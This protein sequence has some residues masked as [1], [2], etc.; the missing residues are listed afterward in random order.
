MNSNEPP[1]KSQPQS[2]QHFRLSVRIFAGLVC[3]I[4]TV[5]CLEIGLRL[6][7]FA[8][9]TDI[10][11]LKDDTYRRLYSPEELRWTEPSLSLQANPCVRRNL[12]GMRWDPRFGFASKILDKACAK[13]LFKSGETKVVL[14]GGSTMDSALAPN[15]LTTIDHYAFGGDASV[16]SINLAESGARLSNML[17]R[18]LYEVIELRPNVTVFLVGPLE[19]T[20]IQYGGLPADDFYWTASVSRRVHHPMMFFLDKAIEESKLAQALLIQ[21]GIYPSARRTGKKIDLTLVDE[22]VDYYFRTQENI[23]AICE[24]Y[25]IKCIFIL[26]PN[27]LVQSHLNA[28]DRLIVQVDLKNFPQDQEITSRGF[29]LLKKGR[30]GNHL[31]DPSGLFEGVPDAYFDV[32]HLTKVGNA[33][34]GKYIH[35]AVVQSVRKDEIR[36]PQH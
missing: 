19:F 33:L 11:R 5:G 25:A 26:Q 10:T 3:F 18:F 27:I 20:S 2:A 30:D 32:V 4:I 29:A 8:M 1:E 24:H 7:S 28:R 17:A 21:T 12:G 15:Y 9:N 35:D 14:L 16:V 22:A 36:P 34:L 31:L 13:D 6:W 23:E